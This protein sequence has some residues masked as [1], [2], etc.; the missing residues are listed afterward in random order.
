MSYIYE[1]VGLSDS[2]KAFA[3]GGRQDN[4]SYKGLEVLFDYLENNQEQT[5]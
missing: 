2:R 1:Q 4:F 3:R 5:S